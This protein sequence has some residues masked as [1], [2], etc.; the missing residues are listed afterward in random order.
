MNYTNN[1]I[2]D[3]AE[4]VWKDIRMLVN[5]YCK[6][7]D[8]LYPE[9]VHD[10]QKLYMEYYLIECGYL[11]YFYDLHFDAVFN[12]IVTFFQLNRITR[13]KKATLRIDIFSY[14]TDRVA[15]NSLFS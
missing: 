8:I 11:K 13:Y 5:R 1:S 2:D 7:C 6:G 9:Y 14:I 15:N 12:N 3:I 4:K 10:C